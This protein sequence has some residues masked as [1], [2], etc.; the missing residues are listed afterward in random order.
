MGIIS[1]YICAFLLLTLLFKFIARLCHWRKLSNILAKSHKCIAFSFLMLSV[2]H[3]FLVAS[4][5]KARSDTVAG[6]GVILLATGIALTVVCHLLKD[7]KKELILHRLFSALML[8]LLVAHVVFSFVELGNYQKAISGIVITEVDM[9]TVEDGTYYGEFD[10][11]YI[12]AK[13]KVTVKGH[14]I[15]DLEL[16]KH[17]HERGEKAEA[18]LSDMLSQ[19]TIEVDAVSS[20]TNSSR[21]IMK[22]CENALTGGESACE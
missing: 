12:Y 4:V 5:L 17:V 3:F 6:T 1:G 14:K 10:A 8:V 19:N 13:V 9:E 20:A 7:K 18:I 2:V 21:V 15:A 16:L 22:A 11:G